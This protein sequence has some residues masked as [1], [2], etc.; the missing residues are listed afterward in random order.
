MSSL[1]KR[2]HLCESDIFNLNHHILVQGG[3]KLTDPSL[4]PDLIKYIHDYVQAFRIR[5]DGDSLV[6]HNDEKPV[7]DIPDHL[8]SMEDKCSYLGE[9]QP[10]Y[11]T[12][13]G[14]MGKTNDSVYFS[15]NHLAGDG[16][17][18]SELVNGFMDNITLRSP[19]GI[20]LSPEVFYAK[21][22]ESYSGTR[23]LPRDKSR[24][25]LISQ[26]ERLPL[27][28]CDT[29]SKKYQIRFP[30]TK[31]VT[32]DKKTK[33][34][35][36]L[37]E[38]TWISLLL[39]VSA[40]NN[41]LER[42]GC[43]TLVDLRRYNL[44]NKKVNNMQNY[45]SIVGPEAEANKGQTLRDLGEAIRSDF[46]SRMNN[47]QQFAF[48]RNDIQDAIPEKKG[49]GIEVSNLGIF[50]LKPPIS[51]LWATLRMRDEDASN[52]ISLLNWSVYNE[53]N[54]EWI[55]LLRYS[56]SQVKDISAKAIGE[57]VRF[58]MQNIPLSTTVG[59]AI[60]EIQHFQNS[61][62]Q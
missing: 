32:Y 51:D 48:F 18:I 45:Y 21:E 39:S 27:N 61:I 8:P 40:F 57:G 14:C 60:K 55:G 58:A 20:I 12:S 24:T 41:T 30:V 25:R 33:I 38:L 4:V 35:H 7:F 50:N 34:V 59:D 5:V 16:G 43:A 52:K 19:E 54:K 23:I 10:H 11:S 6:L 46:I 13:I 37:T 17:L 44:Q 26:G 15:F 22:I 53:S 42:F 31:F 3:I 9:Y 36:K 49:I 29:L 1:M 56:L 47:D 62:L 28:S 2:R